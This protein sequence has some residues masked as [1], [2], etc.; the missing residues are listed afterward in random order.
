MIELLKPYRDKNGYNLLVI[1]Y[2]NG[3]YLCAYANGHK[4]SLTSDEIFEKEQPKKVVEPV[5]FEEETVKTFEEKE[6]QSIEELIKY[7]EPVVN[8]EKPKS[9]DIKPVEKKDDE[10]DFFKDFM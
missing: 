5:Y 2:R 10:D 7:I 4:V 9:K 6:V 3:K 1:S 8:A